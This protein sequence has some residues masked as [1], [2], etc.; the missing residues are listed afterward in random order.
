MKYARGKFTVFLF[1]LKFMINQKQN[2]ALGN[3][4]A[5]Q[6]YDSGTLDSTKNTR[7]WGF[8]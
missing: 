5:Q 6:I 2:Q 1:L 3:I 4:F 8:N 7:H